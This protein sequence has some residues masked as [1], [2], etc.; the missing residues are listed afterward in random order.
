MQP[1]VGDLKMSDEIIN[2]HY[3]P[4]VYLKRFCD[5]GIH[6]NVFDKIKNEI[7]TKQSIE[8]VAA[9]RFFYDID[10]RKLR[11]RMNQEE[12]EAFER[13]F[14]DVNIDQI[15]TQYIEHL[16]GNEIE[17]NYDK[18]IDT[19]LN[20][21]ENMTP[22][23]KKN[24][25]AL[26]PKDQFLLALYISVQMLRSKDF[27]EMIRGTQKAI[28]KLITEIA[29]SRSELPYDSE[30]V[31]PDDKDSIRLQHG[32]MM[33]DE[34]V[35]MDTIHTLLNHYW[36]LVLNETSS[37]FFTSDNPLAKCPHKY[38]GLMSYSGIGSVGIE[39]FFPLSPKI[40]IGM[41]E[42]SYHTE[43]R[44][45][46]RR[47]LKIITPYFIDIYNINMMRCS[48]RSVISPNDDFA[49]ITSAIKKDPRLAERKGVELIYGGKKLL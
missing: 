13:E 17:S 30:L 39:L 24:C 4:R 12:N 33:L 46:D 23:E 5:D 21:I 6:I 44:P 15:D 40:A 47:F 41:Y 9:E 29:H 43:M 8:N 7:R 26:M 45:Y 38:D 49:A 34:N 11:K 48:I 31:F 1:E 37:P 32:N 10:L 36:V 20:R 3:V 14:P 22:W 16:L 19:F 35:I 28:G 18:N 27:R 42:K 2:Q 25:Y